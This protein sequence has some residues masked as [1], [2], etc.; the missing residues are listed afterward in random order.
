MGYVD[1]YTKDGELIKVTIDQKDIPWTYY[2]SS[3]TGSRK[4]FRFNGFDSTE[5][6]SKFLANATRWEEMD[7]Q[8]ELKPLVSTIGL[9]KWY[10]IKDVT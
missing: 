5:R 7:T 1:I 3:Q 4:A 10:V 8:I 2:V 6:L 9:Y